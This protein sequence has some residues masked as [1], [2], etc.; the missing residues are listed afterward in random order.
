MG[1]YLGSCPNMCARR[2]HHFYCTIAGKMAQQGSQKKEDKLY[3]PSSPSVS[4]CS[5]RQ[6]SITHILG[7]LIKS[8]ILWNIQHII[9]IWGMGRAC[10]AIRN[11]LKYRTLC[12]P[13]SVIKKNSPSAH[14]PRR[15]P[16]LLPH[17]V[18]CARL[19]RPQWSSHARWSTT[20]HQPITSCFTAQTW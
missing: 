6:T 14:L 15:A 12:W 20:A 1:L 8:F 2:G 18:P 13:I 4:P 17:H 11:Y 7:S 5:A 16:G 3:K 9:K 19:A 10:Q